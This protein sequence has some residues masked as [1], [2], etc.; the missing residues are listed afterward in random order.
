MQVKILLTTFQQQT[1]LNC[2]LTLLRI[3]MSIGQQTI[4][5]KN[6]VT[7][8]DTNKGSLFTRK[9]LLGVI[10]KQTLKSHNTLA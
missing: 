6:Q 8:Q 10:I 5:I 3:Q 4:Q 1:V 2:N 7:T 9:P